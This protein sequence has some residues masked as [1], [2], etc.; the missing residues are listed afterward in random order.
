MEY[1]SQ[2]LLTSSQEELLAGGLDD[3][4]LDAEWWLDFSGNE[5]ETTDPN[6]LLQEYV[7]L[8]STI[9][10]EEGQNS[11]EWHDAMDSFGS[12]RM[13]NDRVKHFMAYA[14]R[15][16]SEITLEMKLLKYFNEAKAM[17]NENGEDRYRAT[18]FRSWLSVFCKFWTF[19][20]N[21]DLKASTPALEDKIGKWEK[22]QS[23]A[24]Q[25]KVFTVQELLNYYQMPSTPENLA[26]KVYAVIA[27]SFAGRGVEVA[28][29]NFKNITETVETATGEKHIKVT[30][31]R[32]KTRGV[33]EQSFTLITGATEVRIITEYEQ[34][35][36][37]EERS[38]RYF[39]M[40]R[41]GIDGTKI[42]G[43]GRNIGHNTTAKAGIRIATRLGLENP[44][45]YTGHTFRR[46]AATLC[47][48]SGMTL[49][50]IKLLTGKIPYTKTLLITT[51]I[52]MMAI[53]HTQD[54]NRTQW[55][56]N[57]SAN[58]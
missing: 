49:P 18:S 47:A 8:G 3:G 1:S 37:K 25:A 23:M 16:A 33:P 12:K 21:K 32:S 55:H 28:A 50:E 27:I 7:P 53:Q 24:R 54:I 38:G 17:K 45:L 20:K 29:V 4:F 15:D 42:I 41:Y 14:F 6:H 43:T 51:K 48:E 22:M 57:T 36:K 58:R 5:E 44:E 19:C 26:D 34:C 10:G 31:I 52:L 40:L 13:Y 46:T 9:P 11:R 35:F 30:Y 39:R 2:T 56:K